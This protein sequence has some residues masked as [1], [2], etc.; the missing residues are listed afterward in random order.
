M[1][2]ASPGK[3][4]LQQQQ[5]DAEEILTSNGS[6]LESG[7]NTTEMVLDSASKLTQDNDVES[8]VPNGHVLEH[9]V[10]SEAS[11]DENDGHYYEELFFQ[12]Q[13]R[14]QK[15]TM[16]MRQMLESESSTLSEDGMS[17][18]YHECRKLNDLFQ[19]SMLE[20]KLELLAWN[21]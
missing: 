12:Q 11:N 5:Q 7:F 10:L 19:F 9:S 14:L 3:S 6:T 21:N 2:V 18:L 1:S 20:S 13:D 17:Y 16:E 15:I 8:L 4:P